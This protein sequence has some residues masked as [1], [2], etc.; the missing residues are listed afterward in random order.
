VDHGL[1]EGKP[2]LINH[3]PVHAVAGEQAQAA[4]REVGRFWNVGLADGKLRGELWIDV[5]RA[6]EVA[7]GQEAID[8]I[9]NGG[10][11]E[12]STAYWANLIPRPGV[13]NGAAYSGVQTDL[14][15]DHLA[16]LPSGIGR[17]SVADGC[18]APRMNEEQ[19]MSEEFSEETRGVLNR[20]HNAMCSAF[21]N[22]TGSA[23][24]MDG[25]S[26]VVS[27]TSAGGDHVPAIH[28]HLNEAEVVAEASEE[29]ESMADQEAVVVTENE[30]EAEIEEIV[31][32]EGTDIGLD[33]ESEADMS[34]VEV[35]APA[36]LDPALVETLN[37][38]GP[39]GVQALA[40]RM[41]SDLESEQRDRQEV[42]DRLVANSAFTAE[43]LTPMGVEALRKLEDSLNPG[44]Y[45]GLGGP[46]SYEPEQ[47]YN[48]SVRV[49]GLFVRRGSTAN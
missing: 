26:D 8:K 19:V 17:C 42:I 24:P 7:G 41:N 27:A 31:E 40:A 36:A 29:E 32:A 23:V 13:F 12:V 37:A 33:H 46:R 14:V 21:N 47:K 4:E 1:W 39:D 30:A 9:T 11:L 3:P 18:G 6:A 28:I 43:D 49:E 20:L 22:I 25:T 16:L 10:P 44:I 34:E 2:L 48:G 35:S 5:E 15:P 45:V 38:L